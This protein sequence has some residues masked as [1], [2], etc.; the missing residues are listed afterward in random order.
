MYRITVRTFSQRRGDD[1]VRDEVLTFKG[2]SKFT[3][4]GGYLVFQDV[5]TKDWYYFPV[6]NTFIVKEG[7]Q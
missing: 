6:Q 4:E 2:V 1:F 7:E 3:L 5:K